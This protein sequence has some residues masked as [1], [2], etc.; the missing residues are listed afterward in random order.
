MLRSHDGD[1]ALGFRVVYNIVMPSSSGN[2]WI[3]TPDFPSFMSLTAINV[4]VEEKIFRPR[5][6]F[7]L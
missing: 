7:N 4:H 3:H 5:A 1:F 2:V 6:K